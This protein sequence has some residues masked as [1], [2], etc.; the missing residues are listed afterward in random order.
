MAKL[1]K[2]AAYRRIERPYTRMSK[3]RELNYVRGNPHQVISQFDMG[4]KTRKFDYDV[5]MTSKESLQ[6]RQNAIESARQIC[7]RDLET[8][9][10]KDNYHMVIKMFP[11]HILRENPLASGAGAD[12]MSTGM[13]KAFGKT[14]GRACQVY[15]GK[16][17]IVIST[18]KEGIAVAKVALRKATTRLPK[19]CKI[20]LID[21][22][23]LMENKKPIDNKKKAK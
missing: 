3:Y 21:N 5:K 22:K 4:N 14:I 2:F 12:R 10:G 18:N 7:N 11:Y 6:I 16:E 9:L 15:A 8:K 13:Q 17:L 20:E 19:S 1:R 23:K